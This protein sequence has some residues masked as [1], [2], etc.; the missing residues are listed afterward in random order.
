VCL[1][2]RWWTQVRDS[3]RRH[4]LRRVPSSPFAAYL[5]DDRVVRRSRRNCTQSSLHSLEDKEGS[6]W[7]RR[8]GLARARDELLRFPGT[9][10][11]PTFTT[12]GL[13]GHRGTR[14]GEM[15]SC[16]VAPPRPPRTA[17]TLPT[18][19]RP[20]ATPATAA[21]PTTLTGTPRPSAGRPSATT[22]P[23]ATSPRPMERPARRPVSPIPGTPPTGSSPAPSPPPAR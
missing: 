3:A 19:S 16:L 8:N 11:I 20:R 22:A 1:D 17:T 6:V 23:T 21:S 13:T 4:R 5:L 7:S 2:I 9:S 10:S 18:G 12:E 15:S 14:R